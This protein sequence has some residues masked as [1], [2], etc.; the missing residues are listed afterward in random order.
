M[1]INQLYGIHE[2]M[3]AQ[4]LRNRTAL[5]TVRATY[6]EA[7]K[8]APS[9][10]GAALDLCR[11][12]NK[13]M[14]LKDAKP[15]TEF[16][17][18]FVL[19]KLLGD[20]PEALNLLMNPS[21]A[22]EEGEWNDGIRRLSTELT[23]TA[24]HQTLMTMASELNGKGGKRNEAAAE[25]LIDVAEKL[26]GSLAYLSHVPN[27]FVDADAANNMALMVV[28]KNIKKY[29]PGAVGPNKMPIDANDLRQLA[30]LSRVGDRQ[31]VQEEKQQYLA[32]GMN[33]DPDF[34]NSIPETAGEVPL[35]REWYDHFM[36]ESQEPADSRRYG[37]DEEVRP[38]IRKGTYGLLDSYPVEFPT[39]DMLPEGML[40]KHANENT[41][42][43][44]KQAE[45]AKH[46]EQ[47]REAL[48]L[49]PA[50]QSQGQPPSQP[51][52]APA[53]PQAPQGQPNG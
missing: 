40:A 51:Q 1:N 4:D 11:D 46:M 28:G 10:V 36:G 27:S 35:A 15:D 5:K 2:Q 47:R 43:Q 16:L 6:D 9:L 26:R 34:E 50:G 45:V 37:I 19:S 41:R 30:I 38:V 31:R 39:Q 22:T 25:A 12:Y 33:L 24:A 20:K 32:K 23:G 3:L 52:S 42:W 21:A 14:G 7:V 8:Q 13:R 29:Q 48:K 17:H 44:L 49:P 18:K 53:Q